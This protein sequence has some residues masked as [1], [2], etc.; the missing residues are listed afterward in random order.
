MHDF[1]HH[2]ATDTADAV[3][4]LK[5]ADDGKYLAGGQ[6][7]IPVMKQGLAMPSDM[8]D[9][10]AIPDLKGISVV[11]KVVSI[12]AMT[13]HAAVAAD[14]GVRRA[15]PALAELAGKIGDP[16]VRNRGTLGGAIA[17]ADP[18]ADYPAALVGL[19]ATVKTDRREIAADDFF[20][21]LFETALAEDELVTRVDIHIADAGAYV[22]FTNQASR[23]ALVVVFIARGRDAVRVAVTGAGPSVF[24]VE[25]MERALAG[26]FTANAL[27]GISVAADGLNTDLH[28]GAEYR[29]HLI[30]VLA[31]RAVTE[32]G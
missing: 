26:N 17:N 5:N 14:A 7:L 20:T 23:F 32:I 16:H 30:N 18:A 19:G 3:S 31:R 22:K 25:E 10:G 28:A 15:I 11:G 27:V 24:R 1:K 29:A 9:L 21:D 2:R 8:I 12:G 6:T 4:A 13:T